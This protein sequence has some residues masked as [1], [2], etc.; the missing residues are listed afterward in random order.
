M[1]G[2]IN[3]GFIHAQVN[4]VSNNSVAFCFHVES[5]NK[6]CKSKQT[7][8]LGYVRRCVGRAMREQVH[9]CIL[10]LFKDFSL[11]GPGLTSYT[12]VVYNYCVLAHM[13][14]GYGILNGS[15]SDGSQRRLILNDFRSCAL[16]KL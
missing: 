3:L 14:F 13:L 8:K 7:R 16:P 15:V 12:A 4:L 9:K 2:I 10:V 1:N 6:I 5:L 11:V